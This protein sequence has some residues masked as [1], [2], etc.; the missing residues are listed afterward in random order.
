MRDLEARAFDQCADRSVEMAAAADVQ[1]NYPLPDPRRGDPAS[2][3]LTLPAKAVLHE[4]SCTESSAFAPGRHWTLDQI[5]ACPITACP[6]RLRG[7]CTDRIRCVQG[8]PRP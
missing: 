2:V 1:K 6:S 8:S 7:R 4:S 5:T 3:E